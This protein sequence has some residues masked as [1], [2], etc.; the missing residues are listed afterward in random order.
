MD[1]DKELT[2]YDKTCPHDGSELNIMFCE[3]GYVYFKCVGA[4]HKVVY[5]FRDAEEEETYLAIAKHEII[6]KLNDSIAD[7]EHAHWKDLRKELSDFVAR[8]PHF[9]NDIQIRMGLIA[10]ETKGF[11]MI[12]AETYQRCKALFRVIDHV[13]RYEMKLLLKESQNPDVPQTLND[14]AEHRKQYLHLRNLYFQ[15]KLT[16]KIFGKV[17]GLV[18]KIFK[19]F[20][21][22]FWPF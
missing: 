5:K 4:G 7:W 1:M 12:D 10:C 18:G 8:Y 14:Y 19:P 20:L 3:K 2:A 15:T 16:L 9:E 13:Y 22:P 6:T 21:L 11:N 17:M